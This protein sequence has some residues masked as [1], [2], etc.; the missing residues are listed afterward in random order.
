MDQQKY[1]VIIIGAGMSGLAA[2]IRCAYYDKKVCIIEKHFV[3]GG[4]N[5]FYTKDGYRFDVGLHAVTNFTAQGNRKAPLSKLLRQ[6]KIDYDAF[7]L[8]EQN[9]SEI[10]FPSK[11]IQFNN[12]FDF[13]VQQIHNH[14][15]HQIDNFQRLLKIIFD[16]NELDL[17]AAP[18]SAR[19][20]LNE[21]LTDSLLIDMLLCPL[22]YYGSSIEDDMEF[23]QF[24]IMFK[25]IYVEGFSR[26]RDGVRQIT[27]TLVKKYRE[28]GGELRMKTAVQELCIEDERI[29]EVV[30]ENGE[31]LVAD[32]IL[33]SAGYF[34]TLALL[35]PCFFQD[36][37]RSV[38]QMSFIEAIFVLDQPPISLGQEQTIIFYNL[39]HDFL[40]R[41]S[42][43]LVDLDS[44]VICFPNNYQYETQPVDNLLRL[45]NIANYDQWKRFISD[46]IGYQH[47]KEDVLQA[48]MDTT[49]TII[50][51]FRD[52]IIYYDMFTPLTVEKFT[53]HINGAVYGTPNKIKDGRTHL[54]NLFICGTDQGFLGIVGAMLSGISMANLHVLQKN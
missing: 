52:H 48:M 24:V 54:K 50:A 41:K 34:E 43:G 2:G 19:K 7:D 16:Y 8:S 10:Y 45:T 29:K 13:F 32:Q 36:R 27:G 15:P 47:A 49:E 33:S 22:M 42:E 46:P 39:A 3:Y 17:N 18:L 20:V 44:G 25:S 5:S 38:G 31:R 35:K 21:Y 14:F 30:L 28:N 6:L 4:L 53:S 37:I 9:F 12:D 26:P 1:D 51:R 40:Y 11:K 23:G